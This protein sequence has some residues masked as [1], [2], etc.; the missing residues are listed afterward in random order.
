M[1]DR[2]SQTKINLDW[3]V[4]AWRSGEVDDELYQTRLVELFQYSDARRI[5]IEAELIELQE[6]GVKCKELYRYFRHLRTHTPHDE[7]CAAVI[8]FES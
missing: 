1:K 7:G 4:S 5:K 2:K 3:L 8:K 6:V